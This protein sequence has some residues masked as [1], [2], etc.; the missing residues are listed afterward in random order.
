[1]NDSFLSKVNTRD[2]DIF[3][4]AGCQPV[5]S[6]PL[7]DLL[8]FNGPKQTGAAQLLFSF[9]RPENIQS[10]LRRNKKENEQLPKDNFTFSGEISRS[11]HH[12]VRHG[13][14]IEGS[15]FYLLKVHLRP[16]SLL[17]SS[18]NQKTRAIE[19]LAAIRFH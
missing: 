19:W 5:E 4:E 9:F 10:S 18:R 8:R 1:M 6:Q 15:T 12:G 7:G 11:S 14:I 2:T 17:S 3:G 13:I 16:F